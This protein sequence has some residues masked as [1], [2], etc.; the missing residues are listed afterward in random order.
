MKSSFR[1][2]IATVRRYRGRWKKVGR[3]ER[4]RNGMTSREGQMT[5]GA[6]RGIGGR[7]REGREE[8]EGVCS[9]G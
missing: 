4:G 8:R 5:E 1:D 2:A 3:A 7:G 6:G 9:E